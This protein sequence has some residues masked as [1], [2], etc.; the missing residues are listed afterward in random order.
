[1]RRTR[2]AARTAALCTVSFTI[3]TATAA[4]RLLISVD[5]IWASTLTP[6]TGDTTLTPPNENRYGLVDK[7]QNGVWNA[8]NVDPKNMQNINYGGPTGPSGFLKSGDGT[9]TGVRFTITSGHRSGVKTWPPAGGQLREEAAGT[10]YLPDNTLRW[11]LSGLDPAA[12]YNLTMFSYNGGT[13]TANGTAPD[14]NA[15]DAD[16]DANWSGIVPDATGKIRGSLFNTGEAGINGFQVEEIPP[17]L[18][19]TVLILR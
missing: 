4:N 11:E 12:H 10:L 9:T 13:H 2:W 3:A 16:G 15:L 8:F 7:G 6:Y 18:P 5:F 1:M 19:G 14:G 17:R